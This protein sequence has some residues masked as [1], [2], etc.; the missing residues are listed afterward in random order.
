MYCIKKL[1]I[2]LLC[3][4][5]TF[6]LFSC[7]HQEVD[8]MP[9]GVCV[10]EEKSYFGNAERSGRDVKYRCYITLENTSSEH[11]KVKLMGDFGSEYSEG[12][13]TSAKVCGTVEGKEIIEVEPNSSCSFNVVFSF[14]LTENYDD[15]VLVVDRSLPDIF[16]VECDDSESNPVMTAMHGH[17]KAVTHISFCIKLICSKYGHL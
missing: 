9:V 2:A 8:N 1:F 17:G 14:E 10:N 11:S 12:I 16:V 5:L 3:I 7:K 15:K 6:C 4:T 13:I